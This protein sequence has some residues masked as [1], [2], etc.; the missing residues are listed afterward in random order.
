MKYHECVHLRFRYITGVVKSLNVYIRDTKPYPRL[1]LYG[2]K[3]RK[4]SSITF[5]PNLFILTIS[6]FPMVLRTVSGPVRGA[7]SHIPTS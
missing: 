5:S 6:D 4:G 7:P 2:C 3:I 1:I